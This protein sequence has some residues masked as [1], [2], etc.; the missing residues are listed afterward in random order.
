MNSEN[1]KE[2]FSLSAAMSIEH[3]KSYW[4]CPQSDTLCWRCIM[5]HTN[6]ANVFKYVGDDVALA[7]AQPHLQGMCVEVLCILNIKCIKHALTQHK[8]N[9]LI[10]VAD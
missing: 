2:I 10:D 3:A 7:V 1:R 8:A 5:R 9:E 6:R 4:S